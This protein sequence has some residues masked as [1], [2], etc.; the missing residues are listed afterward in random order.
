[1][2][3]TVFIGNIPYDAKEEQ[4][5][6]V[7][8][9]V[10][11]LVN[12]RL[13]FDK[14]TG[15]DRGYALCEYAD[16]KSAIRNLNGRGFHGRTL[17]VDTADGKEITQEE[18]RRRLGG[19]NVEPRSVFIQPVE[20]PDRWQE[21]KQSLG[22]LTPRDIQQIPANARGYVEDLRRVLL[23]PPPQ[24]PND[25][26]VLLDQIMM[27]TQEQIN[28]IPPTERAQVIELRTAIEIRKGLR[29]EK[30]PLVFYY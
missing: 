13:V 5:M 1:M 8:R 16:A 7:M 19:A 12:L 27:L 28:Q 17:R 14:D 24:L 11:S 29:S 20:A 22:N 4:L 15:K 18:T 26:R 23:Q 6:E 21:A 25:Q 10:G 30:I 9:E 3:R 2:S